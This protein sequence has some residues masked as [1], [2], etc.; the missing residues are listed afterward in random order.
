MPCVQFIDGKIVVL[1]LDATL[2][3]GSESNEKDYCIWNK[4]V[5]ALNDI[6]WDVP[7][8]SIDIR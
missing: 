1:V 6:Q 3:E 2:R 4:E 5:G 8:A 7:T